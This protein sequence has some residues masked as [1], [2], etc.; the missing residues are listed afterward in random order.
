MLH[1]ENGAVPSSEIRPVWANCALWFPGISLSP[2]EIEAITSLLREE[3]IPIT[4]HAIGSK[5]AKADGE[6]PRV[7]NSA[8]ARHHGFVR[9]ER[10]DS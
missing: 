7:K 6:S 4:W 10:S 3:S 2:L 9:R 8:H 1:G 5:A